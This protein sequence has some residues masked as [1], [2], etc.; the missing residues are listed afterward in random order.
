M[1][2]RACRLYQDGDNPYDSEK[3]QDIDLLCVGYRGHKTYKYDWNDEHYPPPPPLPPAG[4]APR[5]PPAPKCS[6]GSV[7]TWVPGK[8]SC[9]L[10]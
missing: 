7:P 2:R 6:P 3:K 5:P 8:W 1:L 4:N 9:T 10:W